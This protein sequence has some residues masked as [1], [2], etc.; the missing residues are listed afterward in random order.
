MA[1]APSCDKR[2]RSADR[3]E[4][5]KM[6]RQL[7]LADKSD[8]SGS[9]VS[10]RLNPN[11]LLFDWSRQILESKMVVDWGRAWSPAIILGT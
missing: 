3:L 2:R 5:V 10:R 4:A 6:L 11:I 9:N 1:T 7:S 8:F